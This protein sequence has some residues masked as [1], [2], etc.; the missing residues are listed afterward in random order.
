MRLIVVKGCSQTNE[1]YSARDRWT[2]KRNLGGGEKTMQNHWQEHWVMYLLVLMN[3]QIWMVKRCKEKMI[4][5]Q[6][7]N[8]YASS[9]NCRG[10]SCY[11]VFN[12]REKRMSY[13]RAL[14]EEKLKWQLEFRRD[15][16][17]FLTKWKHRRCAIIKAKQRMHVG[18]WNDER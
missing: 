18:G 12:S 10:S 14:F 1:R 7:S 8:V 9:K 4:V 11:K 2:L 15:M 3:A 17:F 5:G 13:C 16:G 6:G